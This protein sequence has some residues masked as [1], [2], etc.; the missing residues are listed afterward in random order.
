MERFGLSW[1]GKADCIRTLQKSSQATLRPCVKESINF[2]SSQNLFIEGD[3][4]EVLKLLQNSYRNKIKMIYIDPPYN[5]GKEFIYPDDYKDALNSYLN[6]T[7]QKN[8]CGALTTQLEKSGRFHSQWLNMMYPRLYLAHNLLSDDGLIVVH[9]DEHEAH[10]LQMILN[11]IWGPENYLGPLVWD[12]KNPKGDAKAI[13]TQH[14]SIL[15]YAKSKEVFI[16]NCPL[17]RPKKNAEKMLK[18]AKQLFSKLGQSLVPDDLQQVIQKYKLKID[19]NA[20]K[21]TYTLNQVNEDYQKWLKDQNIPA[22]EAAYKYID[23]KGQVQVYRGV[24][25]AW[26]SKKPAPP[27]YCKALIHPKTKQPCPVPDRGWRYSPARMQELLNKQEILFGPDHST[28]PRRKYFLNNNLTE[29]ISSILPFGGSDD[30]LLKDFNIPFENPKPVKL[31]TQL[32]EWFLQNSTRPLVMDFFAGSATLAHATMLYNQKLALQGRPQQAANY[33]CIQLPEKTKPSSEAYKKG[34]AH[35]ADISKHRIYK[36]IEHIKQHDT[37][38]LTSDLG[39][40]V[41]KLAP[42]CFKHWNEQEKIAN[43]K[44]LAIRI[45]D[46]VEYLDPTASQQDILYE[47]MLKNGVRLDEP[48]AQPFAHTYVFKKGQL[49]VCVKPQLSYDFIQKL[50]QHKPVPEKVIF[51][52]AG[53]ANDDELKV[54]AF[55]LF[56]T[57][58][59]HTGQSID[60]CVV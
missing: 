46:Y 22:G 45:Q 19:T 52:D 16:Q 28:Q 12:K 31:A 43:P 42:S 53:F 7:G 8:K 58:A 48:G 29:N 4:L 2:K 57:R 47:I 6:Y 15:I 21:Q 41:L 59:S 40:R 24:S 30:A 23:A 54:N 9:I 51:L 60:F 49:V 36:S 34:Y 44:Q 1:V 20:Y 50:L 11:E 27:E 39:V 32:L 55:H 10:H 14:E 56:K 38:A 25:M 13:A 33:I 18:K 3:N 37:K 17:T 26:P 5:T 35:V